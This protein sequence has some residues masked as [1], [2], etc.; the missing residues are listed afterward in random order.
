MSR[1]IN[2]NQA[3]IAHSFEKFS[4]DG[5]I[6][7]DILENINS[8]FHFE[9]DIRDVLVDYSEKDQ[10]RFFKILLDIKEAV[11]QMTSEENMDIRFSLEDEYFNLLQNLET[12]DTKYKIPSIL[13]KYRKDINPIRALKFELQEIMSMYTIEDDYHIWLVKEFKSEDKINEIV[14]RVKNDIIKIVQMQKKFKRAKEKYSYFV[15]PMSYY[16]CIE[17]EADMVSWIKTLQEFLVWSTQDDI[18]NRYD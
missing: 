8:N 15:L 18:K 11:K 12:N 17:M 7:D 14:F 3:K 13:I 6:T 5:V 10:K 9:S 2:F 4:R 16:H 1:I